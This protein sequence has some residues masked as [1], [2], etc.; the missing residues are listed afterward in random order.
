MTTLIAILISLLGYG[1]PSDFDHMTEEEL[2]YEI[3]VVEAEQEA[4]T[5]DDGGVAGTWDSP[6]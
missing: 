1:T 4:T 3:S 6:S 5:S 2:R